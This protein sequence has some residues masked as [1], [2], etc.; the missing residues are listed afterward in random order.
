V[1]APSQPEQNFFRKCV[2]RID[3]KKRKTLVKK[4]TTIFFSSVQNQRTK[5]KMP[6]LNIVR[7]F[8]SVT[9]DSFRRTLSGR[10]ISTIGLIFVFFFLLAQLIDRRALIDVDNG[11]FVDEETF[12]VNNY[13]SNVNLV[14]RH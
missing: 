7:R 14:R 6:K 11:H 10:L 12:D 1:F 2:S 8:K 3:I 13:G 4:E 9:S 5:K